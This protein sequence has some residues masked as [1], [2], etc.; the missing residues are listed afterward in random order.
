MMLLMMLMM[1]MMMMMMMD[2]DD[3]VSQRGGWRDGGGGRGGI[4]VTRTRHFQVGSS[5]RRRSPQSLQGGNKLKKLPL[6]VAGC[7]G[8][9]PSIGGC[10]KPSLGGGQSWRWQQVELAS[11]WLPRPTIEFGN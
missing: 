11:E 10:Q 4:D 3:E 5:T 1:M 6:P 2:D 7:Q 9:S 8:P